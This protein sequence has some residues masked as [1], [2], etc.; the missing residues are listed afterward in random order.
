MESKNLRDYIAFDDCEKEHFIK[1]SIDGLCKFVFCLIIMFGTGTL[2]YYATRLIELL[3][4][5]E[6]SNFLFG[7]NYLVIVGMMI[8]GYKAIIES[9]PEEEHPTLYDE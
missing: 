7:L 8:R 5:C 3:L 2:A 4:R 9:P 1:R 6:A